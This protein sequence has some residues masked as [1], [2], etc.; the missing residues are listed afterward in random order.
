M[1]TKSRPKGRPNNPM[2]P[3]G[4]PTVKKRPFKCGG[5]IKTK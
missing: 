4:G 3:K 2:I 1:A 5:K